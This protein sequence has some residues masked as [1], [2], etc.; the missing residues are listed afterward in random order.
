MAKNK[1]EHLAII[2]D[3]NGRWAKQRNLSRSEGHRAGASNVKEIIQ[4]MEKYE[5]KYLTLYA[6][7][8]ENWRRS[9]LEISALMNLLKEFLD[10]YEVELM[11]NE[12]K[13]LAIGRLN[14]VPKFARERLEQ[15]INKTKNNKKGVLTLCFSY[16]GREEIVDATK[17]LITDV[18]ADKIT[19]DDLDEKLFGNYLYAPEL[20]DVDLMI[21]TSGELRISNFLLWQLAYSEFFI[22]D[23]LW[24]DFDEEELS[25]AL[26]S[27]YKRERRFGKEQV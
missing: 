17:K 27:F 6:F 22:T 21:R 7:S 24:P 16:S 9:P 25:N 14:K 12:I 13:L 10:S 19:A 26:D 2:M 15:V 20:P 5:I 1:L 8:S 4:L 23:K 11:K 18:K 3:G